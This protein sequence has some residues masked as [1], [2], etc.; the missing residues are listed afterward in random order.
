MAVEQGKVPPSWVHS[1]QLQFE[2]LM[3]YFLQVHRS[4]IASTENFF[5]SLK[6]ICLFSVPTGLVCSN[7]GGACLI[8]H[9]HIYFPKLTNWFSP[10]IIYF[11]RRRAGTNLNLFSPP[12]SH[13]RIFILE[14]GVGHPTIGFTTI[15]LLGNVFGSPHGPFFIK[16][17]AI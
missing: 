15:G 11:A 16:I 1:T 12:L 14:M 13:R 3:F 2:V 10:S 4:Q 8:Y 9:H 7:S 17:I 5:C 6:D